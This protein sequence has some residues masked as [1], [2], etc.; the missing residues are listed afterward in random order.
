LLATGSYVVRIK[1]W[2]MLTTGFPAID[3]ANATVPLAA[4]KIASL[5]F[6]TRSTPR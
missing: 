1:P 6:A 2:S 3:P 5:G 4:A